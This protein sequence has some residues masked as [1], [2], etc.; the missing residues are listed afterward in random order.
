MPRKKNKRLGA[1]DK[2]SKYKS[3][4][5]IELLGNIDAKKPNY[6]IEEENV[7]YNMPNKY[8]IGPG[9][10]ILELAKGGLVS[11]GQGRVIKIKKTKMY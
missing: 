7:L 1:E 8:D 4:S 10:G 6:E 2:L 3:Y 11:K 5:E 9:D